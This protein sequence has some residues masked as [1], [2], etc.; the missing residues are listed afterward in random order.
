[1]NKKIYWVG[2][3]ALV[4]WLSFFIFELVK[5]DKRSVTDLEIPETTKD[6][7]RNLKNQIFVFNPN[8][9]IT[10]WIN[11]ISGQGFLENYKSIE[12]ENFIIFYTP[13]TKAEERAVEVLRYANEA[14]EPMKELMGHYIYPAQVHNRKLQMFVTNSRNE[15]NSIVKYLV[16]MD[17]GLGSVAITCF[18][19]GIMGVLTEGI[20]YSDETWNN[21]DDYAKSTVWHEMNHY[22]FLS[23]LDISQAEMPFTWYIEGLAEF[24]SDAREREE[25]I[26]VAESQTISLT[27]EL[28]NHYD[29]YWVGYSVMKYNN[30]IFGKYKL[31][32]F[33]QASYLSSLERSSLSAFG[34]GLYELEEG[35]KGYIKSK[36]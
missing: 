1:M 23:S 3:F 7:F 8:M 30:E 22:V 10:D 31:K 11:D 15:Y 9:S 33:I 4:L 14:I 18:T 36:Y 35:W 25:E 12:D 16:G 34:I 29:N 21:G 26:S 24:F 19:F 28:P 13:K 5:P 2:G 32:D 27:R 17:A 20:V 6:F